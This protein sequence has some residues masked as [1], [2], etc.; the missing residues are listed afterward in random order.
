MLLRPSLIQRSNSDPFLISSSLLLPSPCKTF[1]THM[2]SNH[3]TAHPW[4][5]PS[6]VQPCNYCGALA[7]TGALW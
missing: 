1:C 3:M 5:L 6:Y 7:C 2:K 4:H